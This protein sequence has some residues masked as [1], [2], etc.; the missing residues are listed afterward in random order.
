VGVAAEE[1]HVDLTQQMDDRSHPSGNPFV[2]TF[3]TSGARKLSAEGQRR[4]IQQWKAQGRKA[5][6]TCGAKHPPPCD[7]GIV[8]KKKISKVKT[9]WCRSCQ[10][11]HL[12]G[13][14]IRNKREAATL[15]T[16]QAYGMAPIPMPTMFPVEPDVVTEHLP[17]AEIRTALI[18][19][20]P[21][22]LGHFSY[23]EQLNLRAEWF[24]NHIPTA[25]SWEQHVFMQYLQESIES[26]RGE[27]NEDTVT[28]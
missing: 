8:K 13:E 14:H 12:F 15:L 20:F 24:P 3:D 28:D 16:Q 5:C 4:L 6:S 9:P 26:H 19:Q 10:E 1:G 25:L 23:Q 17:N 22:L 21:Q 2:D 11:H 27:E 18:H 7:P